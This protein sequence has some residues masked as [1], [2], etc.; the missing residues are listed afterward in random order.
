MKRGFKNIDL[1]V[2]HLTTEPVYMP[3]L[4][5][6]PVEAARRRSNPDH[7]V[8][9][10]QQAS[11]LLVAESLFSYP[12]SERRD[13]N[14]RNKWLARGFAN[15]SFL[16]FAADE[17]SIMRRRL[18]LTRLADD[19]TGFRETKGGLEETIHSKIGH[20]AFLADSLRIAH[21]NEADTSKLRMRLG[22]AMGNIAVDL[23]CLQLTDV[24]NGI[25]EY[26]AQALARWTALDMLRDARTVYPETGGIVPSI[27]QLSLSTTPLST[28]WSHAAPESNQAYHGLQQAQRDFG[29]AA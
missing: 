21:V 16:Q 19:D 15:A 1:P 29:L 18:Q 14:F 3:E 17:P 13:R 2:T 28:Y 4:T 7:T 11:S 20:A 9:L 24:P 27:A 10:E 23:E 5:R 22:A 25:S 8:I 12:M 6:D 26:D